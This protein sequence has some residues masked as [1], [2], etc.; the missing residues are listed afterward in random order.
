M[1]NL[2]VHDELQAECIRTFPT[3]TF[4]VTLLLK[5]EEIETLKVSGASVIAALH[6]GRSHKARMYIEAPFDLMCGFQGSTENSY[7]L[8][9]CATL[10]H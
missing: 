7:L 6:H 3:V 1:A 2:I 5:R 8:M 4:P 9:A 10:L